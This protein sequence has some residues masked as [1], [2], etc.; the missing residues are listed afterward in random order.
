MAINFLSRSN[1][2]VG[3]GPLGSTEAVVPES[4]QQQIETSPIPQSMSVVQ[5][6]LMVNKG[7]LP[8]LPNTSLEAVPS[9]AEYGVPEEDPTTSQA[10]RLK[11]Q[12]QAL[13]DREEQGMRLAEP[14]QVPDF[15]TPG[16]TLE[17]LANAKNQLGQ[18]YDT[19]NVN[20][21][22]HRNYSSEGVEASEVSRLSND[23]QSEVQNNEGV[24]K[25][26]AMLNALASDLK[27][28]PENVNRLGGSMYLS[29]VR[30]AS[31]VRSRKYKSQVDDG[32]SGSGYESYTPDMG[33][34]EAMFGITD[35]K[36]VPEKTKEETKEDW[37]GAVRDI[38]HQPVIQGFIQGVADS[39]GKFTTRPLTPG[40][41]YKSNA[42]SPE[43]AAGIAYT[44]FDKG[45]FQLGKN[46]NGVY[47][48][49]LTEKGLKALDAGLHAASMYDPE[50]RHMN[51]N[52]PIIRSQ[53]HP[54]VN[55]MYAGKQAMFTKDGR[56]L[57]GN[58]DLIDAASNILNGVGLVVNPT[59]L[60]LMQQMAA[61]AFG[62]RDEPKL[63]TGDPT[64]GQPTREDNPLAIGGAFSASPFAETMADLSSDKFVEKY[65]E[66]RDEGKTHGEAAKI[67]GEINNNKVD[68]VFKHLNDYLTGNLGRGARFDQVKRSEA[69]N[70]LFP[71][72]TDINTTNH[73]GTIRPGMNFAVKHSAQVSNNI[74]TDITKIKETARRVFDT[75]GKMGI[76]V[77]QSIQ[78]AL[79]ALPQEQRVLLDAYYQIAK[80]ADDFGYLKMPNN[81]PSPLQFIEALTPEVFNRVAAVGAKLDIWSKGTLPTAND[82]AGM[83]VPKGSLD[84]FFEK[85]EWGPRVS[86]AIMAFN[87]QKASKNGG[88]LVQLDATIET[89]ASQSNAFIMSLMT[90]DLDITNILGNHVEAEAFENVRRQYKDLR[91]KVASTIDDDVDATLTGPDEEE[92]AV[93]I[94]NM[95]AKARQLDP[96]GFDKTY[97]RGIVVAG[98]YGKYAEFMFTEVETMLSKIGTNGTGLD[99]LY[100]HLYKG[101]HRMLVEDLASVYATSMKKHLSNLQGY[102]QVASS[103]G[104]IKA[105][106]DG[107]SR[108]K[109]FGNTEIDIGAIHATPYSDE[110]NLN[111]SVL[112]LEDD[113]IPLIG[114]S[115][116]LASPGDVGRNM[117][118]VNE[119]KARIAKLNLNMLDL[120]EAITEHTTFGDK[121]RK[122]LPVAL[123]QSGDAYQMAAAIVYANQD[124][125][126]KEPLNVKSIHDATI[127]APGSTLLLYNAYNNISPHIMANN[128]KSIFEGL[129]QSMMDDY[130]NA[131]KDV[132]VNK[133]ANIGMLGKYKGLSG[134]FD[135]IYI[136]SKMASRAEERGRVVSEKQIAADKKKKATSDKIINYAIASGWLPPIE[137]N[138]DARNNN[139]ITPQEF[140]NLSRLMLEASGWMDR[141]AKRQ[142]LPEKEH[143][144]YTSRNIVSYNNF[145]QKNEELVAKMKT[146]ANQIVNSK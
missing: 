118:E 20:K 122:T 90:G 126:N 60:S 76:G 75:K 69:V 18:S 104:A 67:I 94:K 55:N 93:A 107:G 91:N 23:L 4:V 3:G 92:K 63:V 10:A 54:P 119:M 49:L 137:R 100:N 46:K 12:D 109:S 79:W 39:M 34:A 124:N 29:M 31:D 111:K 121:A 135:R 38:T 117:N 26:D 145:K 64:T 80:I 25:S 115:R 97:A 61:N 47:F 83:D 41:I 19:F 7:E 44:Y 134:F 116:S 131:A 125:K 5:P 89:D 37:R 114:S 35:K 66:L 144:W 21:T 58:M 53:A 43:V 11:Y 8:Q 140:N 28:T 73:S 87:M 71:T 133:G 51:L 40:A 17:A 81:R 30:A 33:D 123:V 129:Y 77:G 84:N 32:T 15:T 22:K 14:T 110:S 142:F 59:N 88:G 2:P 45:Y 9:Q 52:E 27:L 105:A 99:Y 101:N 95:F 106:Y 13:I 65:N 50:L 70:R 72:A 143:D 42:V 120:Q 141:N 103:I 128:A 78:R 112:G 139:K 68:Q 62:T 57:D 85:K 146:N 138:R 1:A 98:L 24:W 56:V 36:S 132:V 102:Q 136:G 130:K 48:P 16:G 74:Y 86:N 108:I 96:S 6:G 82:L 127:T 113:L